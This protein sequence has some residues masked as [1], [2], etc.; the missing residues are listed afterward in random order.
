MLLEMTSIQFQSLGG[1][2]TSCSFATQPG[3]CCWPAR[4]P[5]CDLLDHECELAITP[6]CRSCFKSESQHPVPS[7]DTL[8]QCRPRSVGQT[9]A[10]GEAGRGAGGP[11]RRRPPRRVMREPE[12]G[13][14]GKREA[15]LTAAGF[16]GSRVLL[17]R[18]L[19]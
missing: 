16:Y 5:C 14:E 1:F 12:G 10:A 6:Q 9:E 8:S 3:P 15:H 11:G 19:S 18:Q 7:A 2:A 4:C 13:R 17:L